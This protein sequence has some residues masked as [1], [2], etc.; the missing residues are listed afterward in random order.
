MLEVCLNDAMENPVGADA[1]KDGQGKL[2]SIGF[3]KTILY[4]VVEEQKKLTGRCCL[5]V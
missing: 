4:R 2:S 1:G 5:L 3:T